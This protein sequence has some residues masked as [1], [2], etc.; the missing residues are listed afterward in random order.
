VKQESYQIQR[1]WNGITYQEILSSNKEA[2]TYIFLYT[3]LD[4]A[5]EK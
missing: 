3:F 5:I 2:V 4:V 1:G